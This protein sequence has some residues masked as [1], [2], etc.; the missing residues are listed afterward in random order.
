MKKGTFFLIFKRPLCCA[1]FFYSLAMPVI[2]AQPLQQT[3]RGIITDRETA[4]P[5]EGVS[6]QLVPG[7]VGTFSDEKG[8]FRFEKIQP[9][10]YTLFFSFIGYE[11]ATLP[12]VEVSS[13]KETLLEVMLKESPVYL[14]EVVVVAAEER[15]NTVNEYALVSG[16]QFSV[17]EGNR[18]AGGYNDPSRM[19]MSFAGVTSSGNDDNNEIVIRGNSP[20]GLL[21][22]LEGV[23]I[24]NPNHFGDGQG[25]TS[26]IISMVNSTSLANS[27]FFT[28][29]FPA[30]YGNA[31]SGVFDLRFRQGNDQ[32]RE[33]KG[34]LSV[35]GMEVAA[36]G[37]IGKKGISYRINGRYST[38]E[39]LLRTG[40][41][42]IDAEGFEPAFRDYNF[43]FLVPAGRLGK[44]KFWGIGG[45]N[46]SEGDYTGFR[47]IDENGMSAIGVS[48]QLPLRGKG[49]FYTVLSS[50]GDFHRYFREN[51][52]SGNWT[53]TYRELHRH[54]ALR[55][56]SF[57]NQRISSSASLR[58]GV[59]FSRLGYEYD[60]NRWDSRTSRMINWLKED[61]ATPMF[62][63][64]SQLKWQPSV[65][66]TITAGAHFNH[67]T[68]T[69]DGNLEPRLGAQLKVSE[70]AFLSAGFGLHSR[71]EPISLYLYKRQGSNNT[72]TQPNRNLQSTGARHAVVGFGTWL[73]P[74]TRMQVEAYY[75]RLFRVPV[76]TSF[77]SFFSILNASSGIPGNILENTGSGKNQGLELT[78]ERLLSNNFYFLL[79]ASL[80]DSQF[81]SKD[82]KWRNTLFNNTF[83]GSGAFGRES[84]IGKSKQH[85][86][87]YNLRLMLRGGNRYIPFNLPLSVQ[88]RSGVLDNSRAYEPR[89]PAYWRIDAGFGYKWNKARST[90]TLRI[91]LQN[92]TNRKNPIRQR[93]DTTL[94]KTYYNYALPIIPI[95]GIQVDFY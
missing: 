1:L 6:V 61:D 82:G 42:N 11:S 84:P 39:L 21:W 59:I 80:F 72:F 63:A 54:R 28:G 85:F 49:Y 12:T 25:A 66:L 60:E 10:R 48:H 30:E 95:F 45:K 91:D 32:R 41:V 36:E 53:T 79:T 57:Y 52:I 90:W 24:P 40:L 37:P 27:D 67:F 29:A 93:F 76:D 23:E 77:K 20:K 5:L 19:V 7:D 73:S 68:L 81:R 56:S 38:L 3:L 70:K 17:Q 13:G 44:F 89:L 9:G 86:L 50:S 8:A 46:L 16:R 14:K 18:Y 71:L 69:K 94:L 92:A 75:Q 55:F 43:T 64:Y 78:L 34:L 58:T 2:V 62:Q 26:G 22:R 33:F 83:A 87:S 31:L 4:Q 35:V 47:D 15:K 74:N 65:N 51:L 88:R